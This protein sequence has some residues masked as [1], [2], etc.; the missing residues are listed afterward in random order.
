MKVEQLFLYLLLHPQ[1]RAILDLNLSC[2]NE[3][4]ADISSSEMNLVIT[5]K[6][7][8]SQPEWFSWAKFILGVCYRPVG[9]EQ[10]SK[11]YSVLL[12]TKLV[13]VSWSQISNCKQEVLWLMRVGPDTT[14]SHHTTN[15]I[16]V[17]LY[18]K[19]SIS[20][21]NRWMSG[22]PSV[23]ITSVAPVRGMKKKITKSHAGALGLKVIFLQ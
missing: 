1:K 7:F 5:R 12:L 11:T 19:Q 13:K 10:Q 22:G 6:I 4:I 17:T 18:C 14:E 9:R 15:Y 23:G 21:F 20:A 3:A 2:W 8:I 16:V